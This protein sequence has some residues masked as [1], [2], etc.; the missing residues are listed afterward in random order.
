KQ[1]R[2]K[3]TIQQMLIVYFYIY[4]C[5]LNFADYRRKFESDFQKADLFGDL[6]PSGFSPPIQRFEVTLRRSIP[7]NLFA[8]GIVRISR[9]EKTSMAF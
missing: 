2:R 9:D 7:A 5:V 1:N 8:S 6:P 3:R 4:V